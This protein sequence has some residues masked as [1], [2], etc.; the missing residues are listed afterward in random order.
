MANGKS[1]VTA[2]GNLSATQVARVWVVKAYQR[3]PL[4]FVK[5]SEISWCGILSGIKNHEYD[6]VW[7]LSR[8]FRWTVE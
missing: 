2:L 4:V 5:K 7:R 8:D 1:K 3:V 6:T